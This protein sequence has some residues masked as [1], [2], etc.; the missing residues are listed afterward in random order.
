MGFGQHSDMGP[1][2]RKSRKDVTA[3]PKKARVK[4]VHPDQMVAH[5]WAHG[6]QDHARTQGGRFYFNGDVIYSYGSHFPIARRIV[7]KDKAVLFLFTKRGY[8][9]TTNG[10]KHVTRRAIPHDATIIEVNNVPQDWQFGTPSSNESW[11][12]N[13][14]ELVLRESKE[15]AESVDKAR[16][17]AASHAAKSIELI[18]EFNLLCGL[19][20]QKKLRIKKQFVT[21]EVLAAARAKSDIHNAKVEE[22]RERQRLRNE[23]EY[24]ERLRQE[25]AEDQELAAKRDEREAAWLAGDNVRLTRVDF[26]DGARFRIKDDLL[27]TSQ[28]M[29]LPIR[30]A[31][32]YL[33]RIR[34]AVEG[35]PASLV[36]G[37][38]TIEAGH[39]SWGV[40]RIHI[41]GHPGLATVTIG[42][43]TF[44]YLE[45]ERIAAVYEGSTTIAS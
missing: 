3:K 8:S 27:E 29:Q 26:Q 9:V 4:E 6:T 43:H 1:A 14:R 12:R 5:L 13:E 11:L 32:V 36:E 20:K 42:C 28:G 21:P 2:E 17:L 16:G 19:L 45:V 7:K 33:G 38:E 40:I 35:F 18:E 41:A 31:L 34:R 39:S 24:A 10:H 23:A 15:Q 30:D 37:E 22:R 44:S 25:A